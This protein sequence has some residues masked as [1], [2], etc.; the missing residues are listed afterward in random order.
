M[1]AQPKMVDGRADLMGGPIS[2]VARSV[3]SS[4]HRSSSVVVAPGEAAYSAL[5]S[6]QAHER[7]STGL[8]LN[9]IP[10]RSLR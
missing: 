10:R 3:A 9:P 2:R 4:I 5:R 6:A 1:F 8:A 7:A